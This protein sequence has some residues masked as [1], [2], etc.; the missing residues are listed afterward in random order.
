MFGLGVYRFGSGV[1]TYEQRLEKLD[2]TSLEE[3]T[4]L[5][6]EKFAVD[7]EFEPRF[8]QYLTRREAGGQNQQLLA[9]N[10]SCIMTLLVA[11]ISNFRC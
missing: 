11:K 7:N 6:L 5:R 1:P 8:G 10:I 4:R 2:M 9:P 3:R